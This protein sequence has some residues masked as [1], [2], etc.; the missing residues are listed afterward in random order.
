M[1]SNCGMYIN[2]ILHSLACWYKAPAYLTDINITAGMLSDH[3]LHD[4]QCRLSVH[5]S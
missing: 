4:S 2:D 3:S 5:A 1:G